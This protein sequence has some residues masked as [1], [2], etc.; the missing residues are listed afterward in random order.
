MNEKLSPAEVARRQGIIDVL[1]HI[2]TSTRLVNYVNDNNN[3]DG[4]H[5]L[6]NLTRGHVPLENPSMYLYGFV[7]IGKF[8]EYSV[9]SDPDILIAVTTQGIK[10]LSVSHTFVRDRDSKRRPVAMVEA[11]EIEDLERE[12]FFDSGA[13]LG[14]ISLEN[15]NFMIGDKIRAF[16][17]R[18]P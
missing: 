7:L 11:I 12:G 5:K 9:Q 1:K 17:S 14:S 10:A 6:Q 4:I 3:L 16:N 8:G 15:F 13:L 2:E 18:I